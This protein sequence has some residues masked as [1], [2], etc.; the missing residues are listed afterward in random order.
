M[1]NREKQSGHQQHSMVAFASAGTRFHM[2]FCFMFWLI[3]TSLRLSFEDMQD[4]APHQISC[5]T[6][7]REY[8]ARK[9]SR[10]SGTSRVQ[11]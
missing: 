4:L 2:A 1:E 11:R 3:D 10:S 7:P 8:T 5:V 9:N 6:S